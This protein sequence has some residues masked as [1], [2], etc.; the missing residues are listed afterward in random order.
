MAAR[1]R[2]TIDLKCE[3]CGEVGSLHVSEE[4]HPFMSSLDRAIDKV[5]GKF[6][7]Q[8][9]G[10]VQVSVTCTNCRHNWQLF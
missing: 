6:A 3:K 9:K 8:M 5:E 10:K 1:D 2:Y 7:A 4:D